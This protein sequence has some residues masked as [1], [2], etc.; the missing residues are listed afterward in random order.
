[1]SKQLHCKHYPHHFTATHEDT[2]ATSHRTNSCSHHWSLTRGTYSGGTERY[3]GPRGISTGP[4]AMYPGPPSI[5]T[6]WQ[7][8][9]TS[10]N[11][12]I[13][14]TPKPFYT[15]SDG[16]YSAPDSH[17]NFRPAQRVSFFGRLHCGTPRLENSRGIEREADGCIT[18]TV[19]VTSTDCAG[20]SQI[21]S[22]VQAYTSTW[23]IE[24]RRH[25]A[26]DVL[27]SEHTG[28]AGWIRQRGA[29]R[30]RLP[31][32]SYVMAHWK[33]SGGD[34]PGTLLPALA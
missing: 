31:Y 19:T 17:P 8:F 6:P 2:Q 14:A 4:H 24:L 7:T 33:E 34:T 22:G 15:H 16:H 18:A 25:E 29:A 21:W 1:M 32:L 5:Q 28:P 10:Q 23:Q 30:T 27:Y 11:T 3:S 20:V 12:T 9:R 13:S 26:A